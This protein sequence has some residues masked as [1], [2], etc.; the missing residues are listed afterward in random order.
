MDDAVKDAVT[1][2][3]TLAAEDIEM[4]ETAVRKKRLA[5]PACF[6]A[7][8]TVE[9][10]LKG[11][12]AFKRLDVERTHDLVR[13]LDSCARLDDRFWAFRD[14]CDALAMYAVTPRYPDDWR[15]IPQ[16]EAREAVRL[17]KEVMEFVKGMLEAG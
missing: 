8:Q 10:C 6:H 1:R 11:F 17:A 7:Q 5:R 4:A 9:K 15:D 3:M 2:W 14:H 13:L 16:S 12:F